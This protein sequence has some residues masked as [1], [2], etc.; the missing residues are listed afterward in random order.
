MIYIFPFF[1]IFLPKTSFLFHYL[2]FSP[3]LSTCFNNCLSSLWKT[4]PHFKIFPHTQASS[5]N[6]VNFSIP[7][8][9]PLST[10]VLYNF[11]EPFPS[12][13]CGLDFTHLEL[14]K[15]LAY[16]L[17]HTYDVKIKEKTI[18]LFYP[19]LNALFYITR[20]VRTLNSRPLRLI[21][22]IQN[23]IT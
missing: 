16:I 17:S 13:R 6:Y 4:L 9:I 8:S 15:T 19:F 22:S 5:T 23:A 7:Q 2:S 18:Y 20:D 14:I 3:N 12:N 21:L 1:L 10:S 11:P